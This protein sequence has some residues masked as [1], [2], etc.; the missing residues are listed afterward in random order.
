MALTPDGRY[1]LA[2]YQLRYGNSTTVPPLV[3][4]AVIRT[5]SRARRAMSFRL[6]GSAGMSVAVGVSIAW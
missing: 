6:P 2:P 1:L 5:S 4:A 3:R